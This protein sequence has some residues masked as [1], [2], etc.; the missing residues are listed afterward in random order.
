MEWWLAFRST[1][2]EFWNDEVAPT[3]DQFVSMT[4]GIAIFH[5]YALKAVGDTDA[6]FLAKSKP[7]IFFVSAGILLFMVT[8]GGNVFSVNCIKKISLFGLF[9]RS[10]YFHFGIG[11]M[12]LALAWIVPWAS[13]ISCGGSQA[14]IASLA[15]STLYLVYSHTRP[16]KLQDGLPPRCK[17]N[18][19]NSL[20]IGV[21]YAIMNSIFLTYAV[22]SFDQLKCM[23]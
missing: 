14:L 21:I 1:T 16:L 12:M 19:L 11:M 2:L 18:F 10:I 8:G 17:I 15:A 23:L 22:H 20:Y 9:L 3:W 5:V 13:G 6:D 7:L 4:V